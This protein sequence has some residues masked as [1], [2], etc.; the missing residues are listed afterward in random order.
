[1]IRSSP[2]SLDVTAA[3]SHRHLDR[4]SVRASAPLLSRRRFSLISE[5]LLFLP[6]KWAAELHAIPEIEDTRTKEAKRNKLRR[7]AAARRTR[8]TV[9][10]SGD[11]T[12]KTELLAEDGM[13]DMGVEADEASVQVKGTTSRS[14]DQ[15]IEL[16]GVTVDDVHQ[17]EF[18]T[19]EK[20]SDF[21]NNYSRLKGLASRQ[22]KKIRNSTGQIVGY[23]FPHLAGFNKVPFTKQVM[24]NDVR[25]QRELQGRDVNVAIRFL[26]GIAGVDGRM[27]WWYKFLDCM[28]GKLP[29]SMITDGDP[30]MRIAIQVVFL[31]DHHRL[32]TWHLLRNATQNIRDLRFTQLLR[33]CMLADM[34]TEE[35]KTHWQSMVDKC[36]IFNVEIFE[37]K[38]TDQC[39]VYRIK[40]YRR[41]DMTWIVVWKPVTNN[42]RFTCM[43]MAS[44]GF[45]CVHILA[46]YVRLH[47]GALPDSLVLRRWA[48]IAKLT[49]ISNACGEETI[50]HAATYRTRLGAFSQICKRLE[51]VACTSDED[52]KQY[53]KK[54]QSDAIVLEIK[55]GLRSA[56]PIVTN[57]LVRQ[58]IKDPARVGTKGTR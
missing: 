43:R 42:F 27:F 37:S 2:L 40:K 47:L 54:L 31:Q 20:A 56:E 49:I 33:H 15:L 3:V 28:Q 7:Y 12:S 21:Y 9:D 6:K 24:Y 36:G 50:D 26:E 39:H 18:N 16:E 48:K 44:F 58:G 14:P 38:V 45:P 4:R 53:S 57:K 35:F 22:Q 1:M 5:P 52:F 23:T 55:Y 32:C 13:Y 8:N 10:S 30:S 19:P 11:S 51:R 29:I 46:V 41:L 34:E 17:M 25:K